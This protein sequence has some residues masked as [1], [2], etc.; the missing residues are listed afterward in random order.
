MMGETVSRQVRRYLNRL[1]A[2]VSAHEAKQRDRAI[3]KLS[4]RSKPGQQK[5]LLTAE[6]TLR[7]HI[8]PRRL[9]HTGITR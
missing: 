7:S 4:K 6:Q 1:R 3:A 5:D 9:R 8:H 2:D